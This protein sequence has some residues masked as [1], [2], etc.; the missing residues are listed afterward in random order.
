MPSVLAEIGAIV[1]HENIE[2]VLVVGD[3][4]DTAAPT[5]EAEATPT[6]P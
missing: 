1:R 5:P 6:A 2:L 3:I 4:F